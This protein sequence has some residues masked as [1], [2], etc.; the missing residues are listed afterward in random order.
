MLVASG[1]GTLL[2]AVLVEKVTCQL[3]AGNHT[4]VAQRGKLLEGRERTKQDKAGR[5][6]II[7]SSTFFDALHLCSSINLP[8]S[9][10]FK[11]Q[12]VLVMKTNSIAK[13]A[14]SSN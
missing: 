1:T 12:F 14:Q 6:I 4:L 2:A 10:S 7:I 13:M 8:R 9:R 11:V 3:E 5:G